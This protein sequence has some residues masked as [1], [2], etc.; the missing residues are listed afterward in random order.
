MKDRGLKKVNLFC[1]DGLAGFSNVVEE[2]FENPK[3]QRCLIHIARNISS[4]EMNFIREIAKATG[5]IRDTIRNELK[6]SK[7]LKDD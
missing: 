7:D 3:I 1:T 5:K 4:L 2:L 6:M